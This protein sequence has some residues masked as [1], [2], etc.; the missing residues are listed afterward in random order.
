MFESENLSSYQAMA[1]GL[2]VVGFDTGCETELLAK[3]GHGVLVPTKNSDA[4]AGAVAG[5]LSLPDRG[6]QIGARGADYCRQHLDIARTIS[7]LT[8]LYRCLGRKEEG[9]CPSVLTV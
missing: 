8:D 3:S 6:V 9:E 1:M 5:I 4:L 7:E 2:P